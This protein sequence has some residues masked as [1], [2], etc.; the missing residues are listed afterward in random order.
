MVKKKIL[1][2]IILIIISLGILVTIKNYE[3]EKG[4]SLPKG[5]HLTWKNETATDTT[6][7]INWREGLK[8]DKFSKI[9]YDTTAKNCE[10]KNYKYYKTPNKLLLK[11]PKNFIRNVELKN[12][13]E[14]TKYFFCIINSAGKSKEYNFKTAP[15]NGTNF[16]FIMGGDTKEKLN[17]TDFNK[18]TKHGMDSEPLFI[19][20][21]GDAITT[22]GNNKL[23]FN[24]FD[25]LQEKFVTSSNRMIPIIHTLGNHELK[26]DKNATNFKE[27]YEY[28][29][30]ELYWY[31]DF[32]NLRVITLFSPGVQTDL[33]SIENQT[34]WLNKTLFEAKGKWIIVQHHQPIYPSYRIPDKTTL[35]MRKQWASLFDKY[36]V[37]LVHEAHDHLYKRSFPIYNEKITSLG[38]GTIYVGDGTWPQARNR[39]INE[40]NKWALEK[41][42]TKKSVQIIKMPSEKYTPR[43]NSTWLNYSAIDPTG[44]IH[45][46]LLIPFDEKINLN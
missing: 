7:V 9:Y 16:S 25:T 12:L 36:K 21:G 33:A 1:F 46:N 6:M 23:W 8:K 27:F 13:K 20:Y 10:Y 41:V 40:K 42:N 29:N 18:L 14:N 22:G 4:F 37:H 31:H 39:K 43:D 32:G 30:N 2:L 28:P 19:L 3:K 15:S 24:W 35:K 26:K 17:S 5:I 38:N 45:D 44:K 34:N 11:N